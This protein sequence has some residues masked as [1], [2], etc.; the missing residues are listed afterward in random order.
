MVSHSI[1]DIGVNEKMRESSAGAA[2]AAPRTFL[3]V[4]T[5]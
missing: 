4:C 2:A 5:L 1:L 3:P